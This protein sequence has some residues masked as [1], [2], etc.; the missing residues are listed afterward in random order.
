MH[1]YARYIMHGDMDNAFHIWDHMILSGNLL[2]ITF[3]L[4]A[5]PT[6]TYKTS[7]LD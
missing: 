7:N 5:F 6:I 1:V 4:I 3:C 2:Q